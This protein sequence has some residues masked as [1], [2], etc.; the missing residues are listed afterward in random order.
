VVEDDDDVRTYTVECLR[1]LGY[2]VHQAHDGA[3]ALRV[4][5]REV[6]PIDLMFT[7]VVMPGMTGRELADKVR[8]A[9]PTVKV[10]FTSGY[11]RNAIVHG[12][13]LD[14]GVE[15][16]SKPFTY[17]SLAQKVADVLDKGRTGRV[18]L[19]EHQ[20]T[21]RAFAAEG[22]AS[23]GYVVDEAQTGAEALAKVRAARG[24]YDAVFLEECLPGQSGDI[25][26]VELRKL[27]AD[28]PM[29]IASDD[30][31]TLS[32]RFVDDRCTGV[33]DKPYNAARMLQALEALGVRC[34]AKIDRS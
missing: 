14:D 28:L 27:H 11:T 22:L 18:L 9:F 34:R 20:P 23:G 19:V 31:A 15:F 13:R 7:D 1:E 33:I 32:A 4:L 5:E 17:I 10:L 12:S 29:L 3:A 26:A 16:I 21:L 2:R 25:V 6:D 24:A 8:E 30:A